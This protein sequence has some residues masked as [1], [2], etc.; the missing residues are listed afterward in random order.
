MVS[1][2][3][4]LRIKLTR[5]HGVLAPN[6]FVLEVVPAA[7]A[8]LAANEAEKAADIN[9]LDVRAVGSFG[10]VYIGGEERD[11]VVAHEAATQA[12]NAVTGKV[13]KK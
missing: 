5:F 12:I 4:K 6:R 9:I 2:V 3:P 10:R 8:A 7:Y 1:V 11:V 13:V